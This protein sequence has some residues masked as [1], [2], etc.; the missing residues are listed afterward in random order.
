ML[1]NLRHIALLLVVFI[2]AGCDPGP[3]PSV[4]VGKH[5]PEIEGQDLDGNVIRL[6]RFKG[7]VV[8]LDFWATSCAPCMRLVPDEKELMNQ[9]KDRPF[10]ILGIN[11]DTDLAQ[12]RAYL[13]K[14]ELPWPNIAG[15]TGRAHH[16]CV[17]CRGAAELCADR[18]RRIDLRPLAR[19]GELR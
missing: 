10:T 12:L 5:A 18:R 6:S 4:A 19:R 9:Y 8:L 16:A 14:S 13:A 11:V 2:I 3:P 7:K 15:R 1:P 17:G